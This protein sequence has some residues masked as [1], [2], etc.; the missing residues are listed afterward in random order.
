[1]FLS[2]LTPHSLSS[3]L[4]LTVRSLLTSPYAY[5]GTACCLARLHIPIPRALAL[6]RDSCVPAEHCLHPWHA[7][8][9]SATC[10]R[11]R[12]TGLLLLACAPQE[13]SIS[14]CGGS[15]SNVV[16][17][18]PSLRNTSRGLRRMWDRRLLG[19]PVGVS[20]VL[21]V[22]RE[23]LGHSTACCSRKA[24]NPKDTWAHPPQ[25]G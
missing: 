14:L 25:P 20:A 5:S 17:A 11:C 22:P 18:Q 7:S 15:V 2:P 16:G 9:A 13:I 1:M 12:N 19:A 23:M 6:S 21:G 24:C 10:W 4:P 8:S 3:T